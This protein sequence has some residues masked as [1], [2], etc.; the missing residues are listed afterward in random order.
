MGRRKEALMG[1]GM[2]SNYSACVPFPP[3]GCWFLLTPFSGC[4][5][6]SVCVACGKPGWEGGG[7][8]VS[9]GG[10]NICSQLAQWKCAFS[11]GKAEAE[12]SRLAF[13][14]VLKS[15]LWGHF[16]TVFYCCYSCVY[17]MTHVLQIR[18]QKCQLKKRDH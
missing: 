12:G 2:Y 18:L 7:T 4:A 10:S 14:R 6:V 15:I 9:M 5:G 17:A 1:H 3:L 16:H 8:A 13:Y 11:L